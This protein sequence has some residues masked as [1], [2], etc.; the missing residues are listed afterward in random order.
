MADISLTSAQIA[1]LTEN[2]A[3]V[4]NYTAGAALT[5]GYAVYISGNRTVKHTAGGAAGTAYGI[6]VV[7]GTPHA[8]GETAIASGAAC[9]VCVFGPVSGYTDGTAGAKAWVSNNAGRI[10]DSAGT[11]AHELGY[12]E[13]TGILFVNPDSAGAGS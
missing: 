1:A 9:A 4:R 3:V 2:G 5:V 6:G 7:V 12:W 11:V 10:A 13:N 8:G